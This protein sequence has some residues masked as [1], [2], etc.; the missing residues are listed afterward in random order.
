VDYTE[1]ALR[2]GADA[3]AAAYLEC[4]LPDGRTVWGVGID[5]DVA[6]AG[7]RAILSAANAATR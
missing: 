7:V 2:T 6:T 4:I 5:H 1:H 3:Q